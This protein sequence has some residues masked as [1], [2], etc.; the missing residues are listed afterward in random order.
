MWR[1]NNFV[2]NLLNLPNSN[3]K[4]DPHYINAHT[5]FVFVQKQK[6]KYECVARR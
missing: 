5:K 3:P 1:E 2:K 6:F 4:P